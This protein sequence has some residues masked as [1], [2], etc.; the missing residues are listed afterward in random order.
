MNQKCNAHFQVCQNQISNLGTNPF[1]WA[2][3]VTFNS[4][5]CQNAIQNATLS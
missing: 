4:K 2:C 5:R 1:L 3:S